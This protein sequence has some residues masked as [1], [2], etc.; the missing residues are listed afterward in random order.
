MISW[1]G[2]KQVESLIGFRALKQPS[3]S[4]MRLR[5]EELTILIRGSKGREICQND[6]LVQI[7]A[8]KRNH[9]KEP[10]QKDLMMVVRLQVGA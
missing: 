10:S 9:D 7:L 4:M 2:F 3:S 1:Q 5:Q 8:R 6:T